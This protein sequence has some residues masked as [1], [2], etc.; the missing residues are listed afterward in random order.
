LFKLKLFQNLKKII[1]RKERKTKTD[2]K[3]RK[4]LNMQKTKRK[5]EKSCENRPKSSG[6]FPKTK[7]KSNAS[8][9]SGP[10]R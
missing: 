3:T 7:K 5:P 1:F 6:T 4:R 10:A 2:P 9:A 8:D